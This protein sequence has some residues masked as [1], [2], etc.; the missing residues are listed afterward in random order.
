[1]SALPRYFAALSDPT[2]FAVI[3]ALIAEGEL[4]AGNLAARTRASGPAM[5]RHLR[6]L[7]EAGLVTQRV[8]GKHRIYRAAPEPIREMAGWIMSRREFW[9]ASLKRLEAAVMAR[10]GGE[11]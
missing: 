1:M 8:A 11:E 5:S 6:V 3:S 4:P 9:E 2:R 7:R 10:K